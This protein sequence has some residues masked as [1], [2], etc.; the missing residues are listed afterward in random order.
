[1][2]APTVLVVDD[3]PDLRLL[4]R[5]LLADTYEIIEASGGR[6]ALDILAARGDIDVVLLDIRMPEVD[7]LQVLAAMSERRLLDRV[8]VIIFS[9]FTDSALT[10]EVLE[11]GA[12]AV[13]GKPF[14]PEQ[15]TDALT[16][17]GRW[18]G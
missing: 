5:T 18:A 15:L 7:G 2:T 9:A 10:R 11:R 14:R 1:M 16:A 13:V 12:H 8:R 4:V 3:E 6:E 17:V